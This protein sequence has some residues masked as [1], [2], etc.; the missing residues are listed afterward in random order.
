MSNSL[1]GQ[2]AML[3]EVFLSL[4]GEGPYIG[5]PMLFVRLGGCNLTCPG[6]GADKAPEYAPVETLDDVQP[7][8]TGCDSAYAWH[9]TYKNLRNQVTVAELIQQIKD[10]LP[11][12]QFEYENGTSIIL[13]WTGGEPLMWQP[14][15]QAVMTHPDLPTASHVLFES[16]ATLPWAMNHRVWCTVTPKIT[17]SLSPKLK[18]SGETYKRRFKPAALRSYAQHFD[19]SEVYLKFVSNG[20]EESFNDI[21]IWLD[22]LQDHSQMDD[23]WDFTFK[24]NPMHWPVYVM[25]EGVYDEQ[26]RAVQADVAAGCIQHGYNFTPRAHLSMFTALIGT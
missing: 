20:S 15:I 16:N 22:E 13:C 12:G 11:N 21:A 17:L 26:C 6:F 4:E 25:P 24:S 8:S 19:S 18:N 3:S 23:R 2:H 5:R 7:P 9:P 14:F 1:R 10:A